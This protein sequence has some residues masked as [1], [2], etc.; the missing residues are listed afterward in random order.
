MDTGWMARGACKAMATEVFFPGTGAGVAAARMICR[1]C[2]V[3]AACLEY[4]LMSHIPH[5]VWG[6]A[7]E[8]ERQRIQRQ[9]RSRIPKRAELEAAPAGAA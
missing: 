1:Q 8:R 9:R 3:R 6:G 5:G 4:A 2:E 7:S